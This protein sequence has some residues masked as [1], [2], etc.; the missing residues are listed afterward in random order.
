MRRVLLPL[1]VIL[2]TVILAG[3]DQSATTQQE[4]TTTLKLLDVTSGGSGKYGM[5]TE[6]YWSDP[7]K[8]GTI[9]RC[10]H[11]RDW[12]GLTSAPTHCEQFALPPQLPRTTTLLAMNMGSGQKTQSIWLVRDQHMVICTHDR[13]FWENATGSVTGC[14]PFARPS[15]VASSALL[16]SINSGSNIAAQSFWS[17][18][19]VCEHEKAQSWFLDNSGFGPVTSCS[20][21]SIPTDKFPEGL[22]A[23]QLAAVTADGSRPWESFWQDAHGTVVRCQ[24]ASNGGLFDE[25]TL[26]QAESCAYWKVPQP[27]GA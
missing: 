18:G 1:L 24:H 14:Q 27:V 17:D 9:L 12:S 4:A 8:P 11:D 21:F 2:F 20:R 7:S 22:Q 13:T 25:K 23:P 5:T 16:V 19:Q 10:F 26:G 6:S 3:C 15:Q